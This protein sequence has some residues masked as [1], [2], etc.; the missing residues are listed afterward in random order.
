[1]MKQIVVKQHQAVL[2]ETDAPF[3]ADHHPLRVLVKIKYSC[4]SPGTELNLI[5][6]SNVPDGFKLGYSASGE[7]IET[8]SKVTD[9]KPGDLVACYGGPYVYHAEQLSV[10]RQLCV[11]LSTRE[12]MRE[13]ALVGLG[14]VSI[15]SVRRL[16][17]Q[18]GETVWVVGLGLLGQLIAQVCQQA[19]YQV[20]A[21]DMNPAR[22]KLA[23]DLGIDA[24]LAS[25]EQV[26]ERIRQFTGGHGFDSIALVAHSTSSKIIEACMQ[27]LAFRGKFA[28]VGNV[29]IEFSREL[30]FQKEA[31]FFIARAAGPGRYDEQY[32][33]QGI[34]YPRSY[35]RWTEGRNMAEYVRQVEKGRL[36]IE[37]LITDEYDINDAPAAYRALKEDVSH[38][39]GVLI[40]Y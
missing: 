14:S 22:I 6:H 36:R 34:D 27:K 18:F 17:M 33:D 7:V 29:P 26:E 8:G 40:R 32:E 20:F 24:C 21:T 12:A 38:A 13:A 11:K 3:L 10:P 1:M 25:D 35:V 2:E 5:H 31:D 23:A 16:S 19:N 15:H 39:L 28:L 4:I 37:P 9:L 30:F